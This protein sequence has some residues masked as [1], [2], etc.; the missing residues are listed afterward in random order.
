MKDVREEN[1]LLSELGFTSMT[2]E[3]YNGETEQLSPVEKVGHF[4]RNGALHP[5]KTNKLTN[6]ISKCKGGVFIFINEH[7]NE[8][9]SFD[10][11]F[12]ELSECME[13]DF[14]EEI[15]KEVYDRMKELDTIVE[16]RFY[17]HTPIGV[18]VIYHYDLDMAL[19]KALN[20]FENSLDINKL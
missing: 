3:A 4:M 13:D 5:K 17:P 15:D 19:D 18:V 11:Y 1:R 9:Q 16:L 6:L 2:E 7:R 10:E 14:R 20:Y 12:E 8:Y